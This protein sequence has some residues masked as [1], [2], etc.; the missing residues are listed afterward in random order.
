[1]TP[2]DWD[3]NTVPR[4]DIAEPGKAP[5]VPEKL[6]V[7][8]LSGP[9]QGKQ[10][11]L[12]RGTYFVGRA[13]HCDL[14]L[15]D[16]AVSRQ[17]LELQMGAR[18][19]VVKD[20][21]S[22]SG[23]FFGGA[24]FNEVTVGAGAVVT[25]GG[26]ELKLATAERSHPILPSTRERF[27]ALLGPSLK[28]RE[29]FAMLELV[30]QSD[31]A[32]LIEGETGTGKELCAEAIRAAGPRARGPFVVCDLAGVSRSLIESE[33]FGHVRGAFTGADR[34]REGAFA[35]AHGGTIFIDEIGELELDMQPRLLRAL[36]SRRIKP[37]GAAQYRD[38]DVRVIAA[39]NRDLREEAKAG[40]FRDDLYHRLAV[41]RVTLPPLR[42]RKDDIPALVQQFLHGKDVEIPPDTLALFTEYDWPG[43]VRELKNVIDRG[44]SLMGQNR[45]LH[46]SL[47]GLEAPP[48]TQG[49]GAHAWPTAVGNEGFREAKERLIASWERDYVVQLL[50]RAGGN[51]SKAAREG[52]LDRVYLHRLIK[53]Y[54][55][56]NVDE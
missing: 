47:L 50:R 42:E 52:G 41:V 15:S 7:I 36:E 35:Q 51:V 48:N 53:K 46:P 29:V 23:S 44:L 54:G 39:T 4:T 55:I 12:E 56:A 13:P 24:K 28:M 26:S 27:G 10:L 21:G 3:P 33:L 19:V 2:D 40:R 14:V 37:V 45:V 30:A 38:V 18:G 9:D 32:V 49:S 22:T 6:R 20:L 31:V 43:N 11:E 16:S 1:M 17:H 25:V 5:V 8:V 34:D